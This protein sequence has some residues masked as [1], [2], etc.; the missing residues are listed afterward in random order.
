MSLHRL[1]GLILAAPA[2][3]LVALEASP[4]GRRLRL[5]RFVPRLLAAIAAGCLLFVAF[6]AY[7]HARFP[8]ALDLM[9][10]PM[11]QHVM[12]A[13]R[14]QPI[15]VAAQ[16]G[17]VPFAYNPLFYFAAVPL[18]RI[19]GPGLLA[20]RLLT[21]LGALGTVLVLFIAV[22]GRTGS[23]WW[24]LMAAGLF[25]A[26]YRVMDAYQDTVH[27]DPLMILAALL[28]TW[29][30]GRNR[31]RLWDWIGMLVLI[32]AFWFKQHGALFAMG[33]VSYLLWRDGWRRSWPFL[34][35]A[36]LLG[37]ALY[38][39][40]GRA[41]FGPEFHYYTEAVPRS[42]SIFDAGT[43]LRPL[44]FFGRW[45]PLLLV[46]AV[47]FVLNRCA[48]DWRK[49]SALLFQFPFAILTAFLGA[50]DPGSSNNVFVPLGVWLL[51]AGTLGFHAFATHPGP[52]PH[53]RLARLALL[54]SFAAL[55]YDPRSVLTSARAGAEA[56]DLVRV[57]RALPGTTYAPDLGQPPGDLRFMPAAHW[58]A[59]DDIMR[60]NA[61]DSLVVEAVLA[62]ALHP[63]GRAWLLTYRR[64]ESYSCLRSLWPCYVMDTNLGER[65]LALEGLERRWPLGWPRFLYRYDPAAVA[66]RNQP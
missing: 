11:L 14:H 4:L 50:L 15:Y 1:L 30:I 42:W 22:S 7:Q 66:A 8:F 61:R 41:L 16:P 32:A 34:M 40:A 64:L 2:F 63:P 49:P 6:L 23:R 37:P 13:V 20:L 17:F 24:G 21:I 29:L 55:A 59:L 27:S 25:A 43:I 54:L 12:R 44:A 9:E 57:I 56:A 19:F 65:F 18:V 35:L 48:A 26:A 38:L 10:Y 31:S 53:P 45:Y 39:F 47:W 46:S 28:G 62:P 58:I 60:G 36:A 5:E 33:G 3:L 51:L 52:W